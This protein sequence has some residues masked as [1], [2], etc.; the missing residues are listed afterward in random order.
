MYYLFSRGKKT[1]DGFHKW[2]RALHKSK[3]EVD[4][5]KKRWWV[6]G[7]STLRLRDVSDNRA[8]N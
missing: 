4:H 7:M 1:G 3:Q 5:E 2:S 6:N 8:D